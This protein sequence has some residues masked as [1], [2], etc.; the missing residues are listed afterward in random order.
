MEAVIF[1][2]DGV[3]VDSEAIYIDL[4]LAQRA[5]R[6]GTTMRNRQITLAD[7]M[8][9]ITHEFSISAKDLTSKRRT[10]V[11]SLPR[12]IGMFLSRRHTDHS[13][14]E[15]GRFFG[16]RDHTTVLYAVKCNP[17][18]LVV[19]TLYDAGIR[20]FDTAS[21]TEI[22]ERLYTSRHT[23]MRHVSHILN[24]LEVDSRTAAAATALRRFLI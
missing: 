1:D 11:I 13:L 4:E 2:C 16:N 3:L 7:I 23:V 15:V 19:D 5:L 9:L 22:A 17:H 20:H 18:P 12:Q 6:D 21:L 8:D 10:Q 14:E 24:K